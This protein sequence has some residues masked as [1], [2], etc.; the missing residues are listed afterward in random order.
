MHYQYT[1]VTEFGVKQKG[2]LEA[3]NIKEVIEYLRNNKLTPITV[4]EEQKSL[5]DQI[6]FMNRVKGGDIV[7]FTRQLASMIQTGLTLIE[8][9]TLLKDQVKDAKMK[10]IIMD[11]I[12]TISGGG[13]F[14]Q[15]LS[16]HKEVFSEV[17]IA[18]VKAAE[19]GG[20][21]DKVL[22][23]LAENLEKSEDLKKKIRS[24]M[25]YPAIITGGVIIVIFIMNLF[26]IP[27]LGKLYE[28][29][30]VKLP[31]TTEI[32][33]GIS[34]A[35]TT[36][37]PLMA[38]AGVVGY[39]FFN[40][41]KK[42]EDGREIIDKI[43]L[44]LPIFGK[45]INLSIETEIARTFSLLISSGTSVLEGLAITANVANNTVYRRA[46]LST[47][48]LVEKGINLSSAFEQ[49]MVFPAIFIQMVKVGESTG[50]IDENLN[51]VAD[52]FE[53]DLNLRIKNLTTAIEPLLLVVLG[54]TVGFL[55]ISV[56][57]PIYGLISSI[58]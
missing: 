15:A 46:I 28:G 23:R 52:Y 24:A 54:V 43:M 58:Q 18:L 37:F 5:S 39:F 2:I 48:T 4:K 49:Q 22:N 19:A 30:N 31:L 16:N 14:S 35:T 32:V 12:A 38:V 1:A 42:S 56:I 57:S 34:H 33:L 44:K 53:R 9:L 26:V 10:T 45:I 13:S 3:N 11:L 50:K 17:Y 55:I 27:Q 8:A 41:F 6:P 51:R 36:F 21:M 20:V 47:S 29:L 40:R 25:I 7:V